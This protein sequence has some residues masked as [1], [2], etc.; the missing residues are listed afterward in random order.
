MKPE[1]K[2]KP[3]IRPEYKLKRLGKPNDEGE[4][5]RYRNLHI[6]KKSNTLWSVYDP[7]RWPKK[8]V[9]W[10]VQFDSLED[11]VDWIDGKIY[12]HFSG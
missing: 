3:M 6:A 7:T 9:S 4:W 10:V 5:Y 2:I 1:Y 8:G 11:A 12:V